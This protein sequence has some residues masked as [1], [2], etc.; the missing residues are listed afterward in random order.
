[1]K[2]NISLV[3]L[4]GLLLVSSL[5]S[6]EDHLVAP[7]ASPRFRLTK[8]IQTGLRYYQSHTLSYNA[9][10]N[11]SQ[12]VAR[13][14]TSASSA[15]NSQGVTTFLQYDAQGRLIISETPIVPGNTTTAGRTIYDYDTK[16]NMI[17]AKKYSAQQGSDF[18]INSLI[19]VEYN[20]QNLPVKTVETNFYP[21]G[22]AVYT[23][24]YSYNGNYLIKTERSYSTGPISN[25]VTTYQ[26][27]NKPNPYY[28]LGYTLDRIGVSP[29]LISPNNVIRPDDQLTYDNNGLLIERVDYYKLDLQQGRTHYTFQYEAY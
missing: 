9:D 24:L 27:D 8:I 4:C 26:Y 16:G 20:S 14:G 18:T 29:Q 11:V 15:E 1:M 21:I 7:P 6:C 28:K 17:A 2:V 19:A 12:Y 3:G 13:G 22:D 5:W 25:P 10:G 23:A